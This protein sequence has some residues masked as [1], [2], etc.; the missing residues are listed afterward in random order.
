MINP[1]IIDRPLTDHD[2]FVGREYSFN[3]L[4]KALTDDERMIMLCGRRYT[5]KTSFVNQL[6]NYVR[7][8]YR[9]VNINWD[10]GSTSDDPFWE[11][12][13]AISEITNKPLLEPKTY[14]D[15][16]YT[17]GFTFLRMVCGQ[18]SRNITLFCLDSLNINE[19]AA[20]GKWETV[21]TCLLDILAGL[22]SA[23]F[24]IVVEGHPSEIVSP[25]AA[26]LPIITLRPLDDQEVEDLVSVPARAAMVYDYELV[27]QL[28]GLAGGEP[29]LVQ[30]LAKLLF[31]SHGNASWLGPNAIDNVIEPAQEIAA[32]A[33]TGLWESATPKAQIMLASFAAM[34]GHHGVGSV[35]DLAL[36]FRQ[37]HLTVP[38]DDIEKAVN[39]LT[40]RDILQRLG[41]GVLQFRSELFRLWLKRSHSLQEILAQFRFYRRSRAR[42]PAAWQGRRV[43]WAGVFLWILA[44]G[45]VAAIVIL[46]R[47][48]NPS[49]FRMTPFTITQQTPMPTISHATEPA[50][51][52]HLVYQGRPNA[53]SKWIIYYMRS[54][55]TAVQ[56]L[57]SGESN[58]TN[59]SLSPDGRKVVFVSDRDGNRE[60]YTMNVDGTNPVNLTHNVA[61]DWTPAWSP[62]GRYIAF[63]S[64]RDGN[65]ELYLMNADGNRPTRMTQNAAA[66]YAPAWSP[67]GK[68]LAFVS[69]RDG[70]LEI[71]ILTLDGAKERRSTSNPATDQS[72]AWSPDGKSIAWASYRD[73]NMEI[74]VAGVD[75]S[76]LRNI[77]QD[78][79]SDDQGPSWAPD[80]QHI[81]LYSNRDHGW[82]IYTL[83]PATGKR[84]NLSQG[85]AI[86][87]F[88]AWGE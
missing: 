35:D 8:S 37:Q 56:P 61:E 73:G 87:Q 36:F 13:A 39:H 17:Y 12:L 26:A 23:A 46:W 57:T 71:Y 3:Q 84:V 30:I 49:L 43:D 55:G 31:D 11:L 33:F 80:G 67:D 20:V 19:L 64:F 4:L 21:L 47:S 82:D 24:L 81:A 53:Q 85:Q 27:R 59:A 69:D 79:V 74:Y 60:I 7:D 66:E 1:Y 75:G 38:K 88:P 22:P 78:P 15:D 6:P 68:S 28:G 9:L 41:G 34:T 76:N 48:R 50:R 51:T 10:P 83:D 52:T 58:D 77:T 70:N 16:P 86:E 62:D 42:K 54:D 72:P 18:G 14:A 45:L 65:W 44:L 25:T 5:G 63:A 2:W 29:F 40:D 32:P